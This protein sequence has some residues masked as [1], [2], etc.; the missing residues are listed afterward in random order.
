MDVLLYSV[1]W[2][3]TKLPVHKMQSTFAMSLHP[4]YFFFI[5]NTHKCPCLNKGS[6]GTQ[7]IM[8]HFI[9]LASHLNPPAEMCRMHQRVVTGFMNVL[10][11]L[12]ISDEDGA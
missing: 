9:D 12:G 3:W 10:T 6:K 11:E 8:V 4:E 7:Q 2:I 5:E 1:W